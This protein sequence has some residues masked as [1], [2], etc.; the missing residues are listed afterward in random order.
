MAYPNDV[1]TAGERVLLHVRPHWK[2]MIGPVL[3]GSL[4]LAILV[5]ALVWNGNQVAVIAAVILALA[6]GLWLAVWPWLVWRSTHYVFTNERVMMRSGVISRD[7]RD[8]P[9]NR[10]NDHSAKQ[11][12]TDRGFGCGTM[13]IESAGERG[14]SVLRS[15]P[16]VDEVQ[17]MLNEIIDQAVS[18]RTPDDEPI[19]ERRPAT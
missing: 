2:A 14:Q 19:P 15:I 18:G 11:T 7:R 16:D 3:A 17:T 8:V 1:L 12:L 4:A 13:I 6:I 10:I 5:A 9:L